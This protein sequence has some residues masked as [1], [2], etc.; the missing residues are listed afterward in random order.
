[1]EQQQEQ[2]GTHC[3]ILRGIARLSDPHYNEER[4]K[5]FVSGYHMPPIDRHSLH[6]LVSFLDAQPRAD[7]DVPQVVVTELTL[8]GVRLSNPSE[9]GLEVLC[10]FFSRRSD[11]TLTKVS[12]VCCNFG[13]SENA[14]QLLAAFQ[15]NT[16]VIDLEISHRIRNLDGAA[17][18]NALSSWMQNIPQLQRLACTRCCLRG[19][20]VVRAF[21]PAL[22]TNRT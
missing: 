14:L 17:L 21:Q 10:S 3:A 16:T 2:R 6:H 18:G 22:Q 19:V 20:E 13:T 1:M 4:H 12:L 11:T 8:Q 5:M 9:D 15:T 7:A